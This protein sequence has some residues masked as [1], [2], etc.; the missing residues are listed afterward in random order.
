M[1]TL[2]ESM[3]L[4]C[5][6]IQNSKDGNVGRTKLQKMIYFAD[7]YL[8]WDVGDYNL[9]Y[10]GPFSRNLATTLKTVRGELVDEKHSGFGPYQ[11]ALTSSGTTFVNE[12]VEN[13]CD[14]KKTCLTR[15][16]FNEL[17]VWSKDDLELTA[18]IDYVKNNVPN[19]SR[20]DLLH[21]VRTI[22]ENFTQDQI[23][24]AYELWTNW[25]EQHNF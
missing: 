19:I 16:M 10:Y 8:G 18:T 14:E 6:A 5:L 25:K 3:G 24:H 11:Y 4:L 15:E 7:R 1:N 13:V 22:K 9:H 2:L 21:K 12:F 17:S 20:E 23:E